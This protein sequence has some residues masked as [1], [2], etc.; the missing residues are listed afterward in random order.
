MI[1]MT[2]ELAELCGIH[3]GDG[4]LRKRQINKTELDISGN[5]EE[6]KYYDDHVIPLINK[7]FNLNIKGRFFSRGTYG[8]VIWNKQIGPLLHEL[9]FP[10]GKKSKIVQIPESILKSENKELYCRFLRGLFDTDGC[11]TF[12]KRYGK[13]YILFKKKYN[14]YPVISISTVSEILSKQVSLVLDKL[15]IDHFIHDYQPKDIRDSYRYITVISGPDRLEKWMNLIGTK[16][17]S[18]LS[19][20]LIWK[21]FGFCPTNLSFKQREEIINNKINLYSMGL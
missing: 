13:N 4:Y 19:R 7:V 11:L 9:G 1:I 17:P 8:F 3:A 18:K 10:Y 5:T 20:Y 2:P 6:R 16:N 21:K 12:Q 14:Y 15:K